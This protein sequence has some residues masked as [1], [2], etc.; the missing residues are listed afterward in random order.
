M[1]KKPKIDKRL[2]KLF[3]DIIPEE[4]DSKPKDKSIV[5]KKEAPLPP[6][7]SL[8]AS[9]LRPTIAPQKAEAVS[10]PKPLQS[11]AS[12]LVSPEPVVTTQDNENISFLIL[13]KYPNRLS[14]LV[15]TAR[16]G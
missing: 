3:K 14:R 13:A 10:S 15:N 11:L 1:S 6:A 4:S 9:G 5:R 16:V 12:V 7:E 8:S 2:D